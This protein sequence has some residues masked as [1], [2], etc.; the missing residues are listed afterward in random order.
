[1]KILISDYEEGLGDNISFSYDLLRRELSRD[2]EIIVEAIS[3]EED[4][5][6]NVRDADYLLTAFAPVTADV[7]SE[8][9]RLKMVSVAATGF[10]FVDIEAATGQKVL[11]SHVSDYCSGEVANH[12]M[13]LLLDLNKKIKVH[14]RN[15]EN[16]GVWDY[17]A[18]QG[19]LRLA[20]SVLGILGFGKIGRALAAR[21]QAF[22]LTVIAYDP[23]MPDE[24]FKN[25]NVERVSPEG[26]YS[27]ADFIS[28]N[29]LLTP[30][31][32]G[33]LNKEAFRKMERAPY[34]INVARGGLICE[35]DLITALDE[36]TISGAGLDVLATE[37][38]VLAGHPLVG[39]SN[40]IITPHSAFY[41]ER[42]L[43]EV[44]ERA[45]WNIIHF[46]HGR[47]ELIQRV[48]NP[49]VSG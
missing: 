17:L 7:I 25:A 8:A 27:R 40:V 5:A 45:A 12:A 33:F 16:R 46:I 23:Y 34:I 13:T 37:N 1:M 26:I 44:Q 29:M 19:C 43:R 11:V 2:T 49:E 4:L 24:V 22:G 47:N 28:L 6:G 10:N 18:A 14:Q 20:D 35:E 39:R 30:E 36:G 9:K 3:G 32:E 41:S 42:S 15:I 21:A 38:P 48:I 31:N